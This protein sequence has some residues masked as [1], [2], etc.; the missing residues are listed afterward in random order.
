[1]PGRRVD[2]RCDGSAQAASGAPG[3]LTGETQSLEQRTEV[4]ITWT[5][6]RVT[7]S[8][9]GSDA[10]GLPP[11]R[12]EVAACIPADVCSANGRGVQHSPRPG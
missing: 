5:E 7:S 12:A 10:A 11:V 9:L 3:V 4:R 6:P 1:M 2:G 8:S